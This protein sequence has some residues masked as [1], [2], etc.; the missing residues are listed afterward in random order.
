MQSK[1]NESLELEQYRIE[2]LK[3]IAPNIVNDQSANWQQR[4]SAQTR[5]FLLKT[6][7]ECL[8]Q[9]GYAL[10]TTQL[11]THTAKISRGALLHHFPTKQEL[12]KQ[13]IEYIF[14]R[15]TDNFCSKVIQFTEQERVVEVAGLEVTWQFMKTTEFQAYQEL[16]MASRTNQ[17]LREIFE[18]KDI[19]YQA[20][21]DD[22]IPHLFPEW[23]DRKEE[24]QLARD[25]VLTCM[26]GLLINFHLI[27]PRSRRAQLRKLIV[28][29]TSQ[30]TLGQLSVPKLSES[31]IEEVD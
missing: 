31:E 10:T 7:M 19:A 22:L 24:L 13:V 16:A 9:H 25:L 14:Y 8:A 1:A 26:H 28:T 23:K 29:I 21:W 6:T 11:V 15:Q 20:L 5:V 30:L 3:R 27:Q 2:A 4:K 18:P 12:I 17:E